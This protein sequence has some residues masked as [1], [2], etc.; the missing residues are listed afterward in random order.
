MTDKINFNEFIMVLNSYMREHWSFEFAITKM[1]YS[2]PSILNSLTK[3]EYLIILDM[4]KHYRICNKKLTL[5]KKNP[6]YFEFMK[7]QIKMIKNE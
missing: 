2:Y 7:S 1:G 4:K 5:D 6:D 3:N